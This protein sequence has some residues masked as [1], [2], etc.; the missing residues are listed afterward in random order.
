MKI[1]AMHPP[2]EPL[3]QVLERLHAAGVEA[4][5]GGSG[6]LF[7]HGLVEQVH[8]WDLTT[9]AAPERVA[10]S[11]TGLRYED[12]TGNHGFETK[13]RLV[14]HLDGQEID[15]ICR[16]AIRTEAGVAHLPTYVTGQYQGLPLGAVEV[17]A[18]AYWLMGRTQKAELALGHLE[19]HG[20]DPARLERVLKEPL[21]GELRA[22][23]E[24]LQ[25]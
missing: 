10:E 15:V 5:L 19:A 13:A 7:A 12:R 6:L 4:A 9:D 2:I 18:A 24:A 8:D 16:F 20:A 22:R 3:R 17:W 25:G 11:L 1:S 23:L 21:P 14:V